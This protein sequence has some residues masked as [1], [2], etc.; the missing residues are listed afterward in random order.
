MILSHLL[1]YRNQRIS[2]PV[3]PPIVEETA[4]PMYPYTGY[5][6]HHYQ[7]PTMYARRNNNYRP[8][9]NHVNYYNQHYQ[10]TLPPKYD[11]Q[12]TQVGGRSSPRVTGG[13]GVGNSSGHRPKYVPNNKS[14]DE[15]ENELS[16]MAIVDQEQKK[17]YNSN[18][19]YKNPNHRP[20]Y[21]K[22]KRNHHLESEKVE[23]EMTR[24][25]E[26][27]HDSN[28]NIK[29]K[30]INTT[31][32]IKHDSVDTSINKKRKGKSTTENKGKYF[33]I[34]SESEILKYFFVS[35]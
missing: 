6:Y 16:R 18:K 2:P 28:N 10:P 19:Y 7:P 31:N 24:R 27:N 30:K 34:S 15:L 17:R 9:N 8:Y 3:I 25:Q 29:K 14:A 23:E 21:N 13:N 1:F 11:N 33:I 32:N 4:P 26:S 22:Q 20:Q 5:G 35:R 12:K